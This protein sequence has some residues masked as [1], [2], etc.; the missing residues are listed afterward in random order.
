LRYAAA[1]WGHAR[2]LRYDKYLAAGMPVFQQ[3]D[4][5]V[6][7]P[8][9]FDTDAVSERLD[10]KDD[11]TLPGS[12]E[13]EAARTR[14]MNAQADLAEHQLNLKRSEVVSIDVVAEI[15]GRQY[16]SLRGHLLAIP[17]TLASSP[18]RQRMSSWVTSPAGLFLSFIAA[19]FATLP[20]Y[21]SPEHR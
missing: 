1:L 13:Y 17:A 11:E 9:Q 14:K 20:S 5:D 6:G 3:A 18:P 4:R 12:E 21:A 8:W 10:H 15:V 19:V 7:R 2:F 16:G